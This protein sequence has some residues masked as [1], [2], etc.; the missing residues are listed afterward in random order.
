M[1]AGYELRTGSPA[2]PSNQSPI[3]SAVDSSGSMATSWEGTAILRPCQRISMSMSAEQASSGAIRRTSTVSPLP[4]GETTLLMP[5]TVGIVRLHSGFVYSRKPVCSSNPI[6]FIGNVRL[7][8]IVTSIEARLH[9]SRSNAI[10]KALPVG[11]SVFSAFPPRVAMSEVR[12]LFLSVAAHPCGN[13]KPST[14][15]RSAA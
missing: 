12:H 6:I 1:K 4:S 5:G 9:S 2:P 7:K 15:R 8:N 14:H 13:K 11:K 3:A 10:P